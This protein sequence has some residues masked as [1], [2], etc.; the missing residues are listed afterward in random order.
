MTDTPQPAETRRSRRRNGSSNF[1]NWLSVTLSVVA[2][3]ISGVS[4]WATWEQVKVDREASTESLEVVEYHVTVVQDGEVAD[5]NSSIF[6]QDD[7]AAFAPGA[8]VLVDIEIANVGRADGLLSSVS[9]LRDGRRQ[10]DFEVVNCRE[11]RDA[12]LVGQCRLPLPIEA[13]GRLFI[14]VDLDAELI[15]NLACPPPDQ[16]FK[17]VLR[18]SSGQEIIADEGSVISTAFECPEASN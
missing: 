10:V 6:E 3:L 2:V 7:A 5:F 8:H 17:F 9:I 1:L 12:E 18:S 4:A 16:S 15:E 14:A 11:D 13:G